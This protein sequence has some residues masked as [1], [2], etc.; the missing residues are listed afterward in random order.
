MITRNDKNNCA[1]IKTVTKNN[2]GKEFIKSCYK[3]Y[4]RF[5]ILEK[6]EREKEIRK[7]ILD[8]NYL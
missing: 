8:L 3:N 6:R 5:E 4:Q 1:I 2:T 7:I